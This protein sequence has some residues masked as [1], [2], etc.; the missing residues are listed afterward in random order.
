MGLLTEKE[1]QKMA[2]AHGKLF[3]AVCD[4]CGRCIKVGTPYVVRKYIKV[5]WEGTGQKPFNWNLRVP[6][7]I[8]CL[9]C[10][11]E[12]IEPYIQKRKVVIGGKGRKKLTEDEIKLL[13]KADGI[14]V[15]HLVKRFLRKSEDGILT[16][17]LKNKIY[18]RAKGGP[19]PPIK[20][21]TIGKVLRIL[22]K[23]K[24]VKCKNSL[25]TLVEDK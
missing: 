4:D 10:N 9:D 20:K 2:L 25:W 18:A 5:K 11:R 8:R 12:K 23:A 22:K 17:D 13:S 3:I 24:V 6:D 16:K 21:A 19:T 14:V 15:K 7:K 1:K